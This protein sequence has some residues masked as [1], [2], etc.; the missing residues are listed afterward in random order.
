MLE[1]GKGS[2]TGKL[3][4]VTL[5]E[6]DLQYVIR[7][8]LSGKIEEKI[9]QDD[10]FSKANYISRKNYLIE[11]AILKKRLIYNLSKLTRNPTLHNMTD[12][13]ACYDR[14]LP[15]IASILQ[16][17]MGVERKAI[18]LL[19]KVIPIFKYYICTIY[20]VSNTCYRGEIDPLAGSG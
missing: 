10:W 3:W 1:K 20:G 9:E 16:E 4:T 2:I 11:T 12:L 13:E 15:N 14:Q 5:I 17:S 7:M 18:K 19:T 8:Y 6:A